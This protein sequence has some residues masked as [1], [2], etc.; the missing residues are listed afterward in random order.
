MQKPLIDDDEIQLEDNYIVRFKEL[1]YS[2]S[3][4]VIKKFKLFR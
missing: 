4:S 1:F 2:E 3:L